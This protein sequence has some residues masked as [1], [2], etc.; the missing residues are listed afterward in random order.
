MTANV[1]V[2]VVVLLAVSG[3][4]YLN[5]WVNG[6]KFE[7]DHRGRKCGAPSADEFRRVQK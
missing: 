4:G 1:L 7:R 3:G 5:G 6:R 2:I